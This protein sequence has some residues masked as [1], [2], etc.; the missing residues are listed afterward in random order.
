MDI[1]LNWIGILVMT[2]AG[3]ALGALWHGPIFGKLWMKIHHGDKKFTDAEMKKSMEGLW[4]LMLTEF[5][6]TFLMVMTLD[7]LINIIPPNYS[8]VHIAFMVWLGYVLPTMMSTVIWGG[9]AKK[10]M[11]T[12]IILSSICRLLGL[13]ATGYVLSVW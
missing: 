4:K 3:F 7:F 2:I 6:A 1:S 11:C 5:V 13:L 8:G 10:W 12:K 9:D